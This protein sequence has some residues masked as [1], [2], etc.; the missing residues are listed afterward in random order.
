[1]QT[2]QM[3][4]PKEFLSLLRDMG[5]LRAD[6]DL[7]MQLYAFAATVTGFYLTDPLIADEDQVSLE[8]KAQALAQ[9]IQDAFEP[10]TPPSPVALREE[11]APRMILFLEQICDFCEQQMQER[12]V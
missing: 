7:S 12:M 1:M 3:A 11:V 2:R 9:T 4:D 5:L 10:E 8:T 6:V